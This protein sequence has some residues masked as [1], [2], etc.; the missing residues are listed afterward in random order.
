MI[1]LG[2]EAHDRNAGFA[3][4][5]GNG[6]DDGRRAAQAR[7]QRGV[8]V[9][10]AV[11]RNIEHALR[12]DAPV[13]NDHVGICRGKFGVPEFGG[14]EHG[15]AVCLCED[16]GGRRRE[17]LFATDRFVGLSDH[18]DNVK[19]RIPDEGLQILGGKGRCAEKD[20]LHTRGGI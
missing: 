15:N 5:F 19:Q 3:E 9:D 4:S 17:D 6:S 2:V 18:G 11:A 16:F 7:K 13:G 8:H 1:H 20:D 10:A 14:L 12:N